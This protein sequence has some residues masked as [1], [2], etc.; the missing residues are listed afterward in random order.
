MTSYGKRAVI[1]AR[2][3]SHNQRDE[4]IEIQLEHSRAYC[5]EHGLTVVGEYCDH[6]QSGR[7]SERA[8]FQRMMDDAKRGLFDHVVIW[9]V[10]R[11]MRN[12]DEMS[13]ARLMLRKAGVDILYA[14]EQITEGSSGVLQLGMLE[15]LSEYES[16]LT[17]ERIR[18]GVRKNA[19]RCMANGQKLFGWD[20][21]PETKRYVVN[22]T[23]ARAL[24]TARDMVVAG[25]T[26]AEATRALASYRTKRGVPV[27]QAAL[28]KFLRRRQNCGTY[29]YA[30]VEVEGGMPAL[31][32]EAE[33]D[34]VERVLANRRRPHRYAKLDQ[35][36]Y[37]LSGRVVCAGCGRRLFGTAGTSKTGR[38]Y[39]YY[40]C[41]DC[42]RNARKEAL[43]GMAAALVRGAVADP[44]VRG[45]I[46]R[47]MVEFERESAGPPRSDGIRKELAEISRS[48]ERIWQAIEQGF[49]PP[50][51]RERTEALR[52]REAVLQGELAR[53]LAEEASSVSHEGVVEWLEAVAPEVDDAELIRAFVARAWH[54]ADGWL[55]VAMAFDGMP[56]EDCPDIDTNTP[57][58]DAARVFVNWS[59]GGGADEVCEPMELQ[60]RG[61]CV[62]LRARVP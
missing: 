14:G 62:I 36:D 8:E 29:R 55:A 25:S 23:E 51:G 41:P 50:G 43:E 21:D 49:A 26:M 2:Y 34:E 60:V 58:D 44:E 46:A 53:A 24:R 4:S 10:T 37:A 5:E 17:A 39:H 40:R 47:L 38:L 18:D 54:S 16:E 32:T 22:E 57:A 61:R 19:E 42:R 20:I 45:L 12:R 30:G 48:Y 35:G 27:T 6:A 33:Q 59:Y 1:Y 28:T 52:K 9:K 11:I 31:W 13:L 15:V 3:S 56:P 7:S